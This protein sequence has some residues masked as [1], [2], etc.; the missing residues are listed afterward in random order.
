MNILMVNEHKAGGG[1]EKYVV[2]LGEILKQERHN[3]FFL[4]FSV[5]DQSRLSSNEYLVPIKQGY[6]KLIFD[7]KSYLSI[8]KIVKMVAPDLVIVN[9]IFSSPITQ[10]LALRGY[11]VIQ[12]VHDYSIVCPR[13]NCVDDTNAVCPGYICGKC[14]TKCR[15]HG[16][17]WQLALKLWQVKRMEALRKK[18]VSVLISPSQKLCTYLEEYGYHAY[19]VPNPVELKVHQKSSVKNQREYIYLG[20][21]NENKG[22]IELMHAFSKFS[23]GKDVHLSLYGNITDDVAR[24]LIQE[25]HNEKI[26]YK[27]HVGSEAIPQLIAEAYAIIV[28][29]KWMENY[30]TTVL[31]GFAYKTLVIGS[32]CGGIPE[33]LADGRGICYEYGKLDEALNEA[34]KLTETVYERYQEKGYRYVIQ[35]NEMER[36]ARKIISVLYEAMRMYK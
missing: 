5:A 11:P 27:G 34:Y 36:Y 14:L 20:V 17:R 3:V 10:L 4:Y 35:N 25:N 18:Y 30:P 2:N 23:K 15:Y 9:N 12:V 26:S 13:S 31:E 1:A 29:S 22:I 21:I 19:Y 33:Q 8:R 6:K 7:I 32:D 28:P 16:S 24:R